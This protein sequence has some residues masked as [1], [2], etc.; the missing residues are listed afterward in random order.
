MRLVVRLA[1]NHIYQP[2]LN[3]PAAMVPF[4]GSM[5]LVSTWTNATGIVGAPALNLHNRMFLDKYAQALE[6]LN[7]QVETSEQTLAAIPTEASSLPANVE[8][9]IAAGTPR[10]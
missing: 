3:L 7:R 8:D 4:L 5:F 10:F 1:L 2:P 6:A 9:E